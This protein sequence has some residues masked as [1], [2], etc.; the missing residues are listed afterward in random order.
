MKH[1]PIRFLAVS[2]ILASIFCVIIFNVQ[3]LWMN[4]MGAGAIKEI[5]A[6]YMSGMSKQV[7]SHFQTIIELRLSQVGAL[8]DAVSPAQNRDSMAQRVEIGRASCRER[9]WLKV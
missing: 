9:V 8:V 7:A 3:T 4:R 1:R 5:G 6:I 2:L